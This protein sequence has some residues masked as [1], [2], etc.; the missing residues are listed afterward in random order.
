[1]SRPGAGP[2]RW[3]DLIEGPRRTVPEARRLATRLSRRDFVRVGRDLAALI[4]LGT[5]GACR[6][7]RGVRLASYPFPH[8]VASGD[9]GP[10]GAVLWTRLSAEAL[11]EAGA[12]GQPVP[13]RWEVAADDG[14]RRIVQS[15][16]QMALPELGH[17]VHVEVGGLDPGRPYWYRFAAS[18]EATPSGRTVTLPAPGTAADR[19]RFAFASCQ[20]Y[21]HGFYTAYRHMAGDDLDL[22]LHLGDYIYERRFGNG[23]VRQHEAGEVY[24]LDEYRARYAL[25]RSDPD[26]QAA[27]AAC[28][29]V[30]TPDDHEVDNNWAGDTP[31]DDQLPAQFLLRRTA[32][33]QAYYEFMPLRR[34]S[35]PTGTHIPLHRRFHCGDLADLHILDSRQYRSDQ[36]CGDGR[37][38]LC[39]EALVPERTMLGSEQ[40]RW[41][42]DGLAG[43]SSRW[44]VLANQVMIARL[45]GAAPDGGPLVSMDRWDGYPSAQEGL[46]SFLE[47]TRPPNPVV[48]TGDIH[49]NWAADLKA[50][51]RDPASATVGA[52]LVGTSITSGGDG[53]DV[54]DS[55]ED[56]LARNPHVHF[57][58]GQ[59]GYVRCDVTRE[60]L[61]ADYR[62][63]PYVTRPDAEAVTRAAFVVEDGRAGLQRA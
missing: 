3:Y 38:V 57:F 49:S 37:R 17:S 53:T 6:G 46:L 11:R 60:R 42:F 50:D 61:A 33:F 18:G 7:D 51:F 35:V 41:L 14:F 26:L 40:E 30:V 24:T 25:Y 21:E 8:G 45:E 27:H 15:G 10:D 13:V 29:W 58:N 4:A 2:R 32:A 63:L 55:T 9:P 36:A 47:G 62:V 54:R 12:A 34:S 52:E 16:A 20:N 31:E 39:P 59:R 19:L 56:T 44:N 48:V 22:V 28:P 23:Q 43:S 1:M 5:V